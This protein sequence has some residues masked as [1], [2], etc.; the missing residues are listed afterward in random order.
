MANL[1][2]DVSIRISYRSSISLV[3]MHDLTESVDVQ[4]LYHLCTVNSHI[5]VALGSF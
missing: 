3:F 1:A 2:N 4:N 5:R